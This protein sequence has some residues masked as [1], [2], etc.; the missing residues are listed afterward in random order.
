[1][2]L[3]RPTCLEE[4]SLIFIFSH[5]AKSVTAPLGYI[6][7]G[8]QISPLH[9][10]RFGSD[11]SLGG[12]KRLSPINGWDAPFKSSHTTCNH[13]HTQNEPHAKV[14]CLSVLNISANSAVRINI[15]T[16]FPK[17][18]FLWCCVMQQVACSYREHCQHLASLCVS[19][20][21]SV[22]VTPGQHTGVDTVKA[23]AQQ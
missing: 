11:S 23:A 6:P 22:Q 7:G 5:M 9:H 2:S 19:E 10:R 21:S 18:S 1:M 12:M 4:P 3:T 13:H 15:R 8:S 14:W 20:S 17:N 16:A